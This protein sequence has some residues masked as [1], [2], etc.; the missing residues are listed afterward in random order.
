MA[1]EGQEEWVGQAGA[2]AGVVGEQ[3]E[4]GGDGAGVGEVEEAE[5]GEGAG[6]GGDGEGAGR[7]GALGL[8]RGQTL[9][10]EK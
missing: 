2:G 3:V 6:A 9:E 8:C 10:G 4:A 1:A 5:G 7:L